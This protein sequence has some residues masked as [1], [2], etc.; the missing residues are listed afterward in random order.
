M[1]VWSEVQSTVYV[2]TCSAHGQ[3]SLCYHIRNFLNL[4]SKKTIADVATQWPLTLSAAHTD[5]DIYS[6]MHFTSNTHGPVAGNLWL[7]RLANSHCSL[8][9]TQIINFP[10]L[11]VFLQLNLNWECCARSVI[12]SLWWVLKMMMENTSS[13][14]NII[15][16]GMQVNTCISWYWRCHNFHCHFSGIVCTRHGYP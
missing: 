11:G 5:C 3:K 9:P 10:R 1:G 16:S 4:V 8:W 14:H 15:N 13:A 12:K 6:W 7:V 2:G